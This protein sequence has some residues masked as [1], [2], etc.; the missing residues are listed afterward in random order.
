MEMRSNTPNGLVLRIR[1]SEEIGDVSPGFV[2][3]VFEK[4]QIWCWEVDFLCQR[5]TPSCVDRSRCRKEYEYL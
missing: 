2:C 1:V 4:G 5:L 3:E